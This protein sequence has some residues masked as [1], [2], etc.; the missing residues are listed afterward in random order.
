MVYRLSGFLWKAEFCQ[1]STRVLSR[2]RAACYQP[3]EVMFGG[4]G[5]SLSDSPN[6]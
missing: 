1:S 2:S 4:E 6:P 3:L 5:D